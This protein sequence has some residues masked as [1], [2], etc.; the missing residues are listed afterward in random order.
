MIE[1]LSYFGT[2]ENN[3]RMNDYKFLRN[4]VKLSF[5]VGL[6]QEK[7]LICYRPASEYNSYYGY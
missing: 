3:I 2:V 5:Y 1:I 4:E 6:P 7:G